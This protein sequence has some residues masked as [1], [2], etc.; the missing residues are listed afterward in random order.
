[1]NDKKDNNNDADEPEVIVVPPE[2]QDVMPPED[3]N[4][5]E[6]AFIDAEAT[7]VDDQAA[8]KRGS[9][10]GLW[11][12]L[13]V[14]AAFVGGFVA[15][16]KLAP[17]LDPWLP[18]SLKPGASRLTEV[19]KAL[20]ELALRIATLKEDAVQPAVVDDLE[21]RFKTAVDDLQG[22]ITELAARP[23]LPADFTERVASLN[24]RIEEIAAQINKQKPS[25]GTAADTGTM[26][27]EALAQL[28]AMAATVADLVTRTVQLEAR[29][30]AENGA[31][32]E[33]ATVAVT[34]A[35]DHEHIHDMSHDHA[36]LEAG[37]ADLKSLSND[38]LARLSAAEARLAAMADQASGGTG[39]ALVAAVGQ[40]R[41]RVDRGQAYDA[42]LG[43]VMA[44]VAADKAAGEDAKALLA[45][46][47]LAKAGITT[48]PVLAQKFTALAADV[49]IAA[50]PAPTNWLE[51]VWRRLAS[52]V[53][54]RRTGEMAT[55][56]KGD[57]VASRVAR[58]EAFLGTS[59]L[60]SAVQEMTAL[61]EAPAAVI[62]PWLALA[63]QHLKAQ[64]ALE[65]LTR[66]A[67][68]RLAR[69]AGAAE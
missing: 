4:S 43:T 19:T 25:D 31:P 63:E 34:A 64:T 59:D 16:P 27:D 42:D 28:Q 21:A 23:Q 29:P 32:A 15:W 3:Q 50:R 38:L 30:Q 45:D 41:R 12:V 61:P 67:V 26:A 54:I 53:S 51:S 39:A 11:I 37:I 57:D 20:D 69:P 40:L 35:H 60:R 2:D 13:L 56:V 49:L 14:M 6:A 33:A 68:Q 24:S 7:P 9:R 5:D 52:M 46:L 62:A 1:M 58:T 48:L 65:Q 17:A 8:V 55:D 22:K 10:L 66:Q 44:L 18:E 36:G 47:Q